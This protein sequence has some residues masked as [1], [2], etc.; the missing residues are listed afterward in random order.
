VA[1]TQASLVLVPLDYVGVP[2]ANQAYLFVKN[3]GSVALARICARLERELW[4]RPV[5]GLHPTAVVA[6]GVAI[7]TSATVG[8][9]CVI[10]EGAR[11]G[12]HVHLQARVFVGRDAVL[13][14]GLLVDAWLCR[15]RSVSG[16]NGCGLQ[17]GVVVGSDGLGYEFTN[18]RHEKVPQVGTV[19]IENDVEIGANTTL[20]RARFSRTVVGEGTKIDNLVQ[21]AHN[22]T[23]GRHCLVCAQAG[24]SG[25][26][27]VE[28]FV[29]IGG[30]AGL[31][32]HLPVGRGAKIDGQTGV[33]LR[34]GEQAAL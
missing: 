9:F 12:D 23:I 3:P 11:I 1:G 26:T 27:V 14:Q 30:Q 25:G 21:V 4:P 10:E 34:R 22:V 2:R 29:I 13:G 18:G 16:V 24:I 20:D 8:P 6:P 5:P 33:E 19:V 31:A 32:G 15:T 28:D 7:P 17:A